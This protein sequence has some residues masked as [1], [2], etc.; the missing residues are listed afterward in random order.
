[1]VNSHTGV[2]LNASESC[3]VCNQIAWKFLSSLKMH[4][5]SALCGFSKSLLHDIKQSHM[6]TSI[7]LCKSRDMTGNQVKQKLRRQ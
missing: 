1:M 3:S 5:K 4:I 6:F 7:L 2:L